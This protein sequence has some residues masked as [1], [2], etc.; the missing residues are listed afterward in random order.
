MVMNRSLPRITSPRMYTLQKKLR[1]QNGRKGNQA[2]LCTNPD[3]PR[4]FCQQACLEWYLLPQSDV[5]PKDLLL[6]LIRVKTKVSSL[7]S[8]PNSQVSQYLE[9]EKAQMLLTGLQFSRFPDLAN[10][11]SF[12]TFWDPSQL[13]ESELALPSSGMLSH[14]HSSWFA[15]ASQ[16][17]SAKEAGSLLMKEQEVCALGEFLCVSEITVLKFSLAGSQITVTRQAGVRVIL[18]HW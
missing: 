2:F 10:V 14:Y 18:C 4:E 5:A 3:S 13:E 7:L 15:G 11:P 9:V 8:S 17:K 6:F 12:W 16:A 1:S